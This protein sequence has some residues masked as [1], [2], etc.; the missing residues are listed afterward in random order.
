M[1]IRHCLLVLGR[2]PPHFQLAGAVS[3]EEQPTSCELDGSHLFLGEERAHPI[4]PGR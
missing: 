1:H 3:G 4:E 2:P